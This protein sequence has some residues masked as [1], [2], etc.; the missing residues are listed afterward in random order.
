MPQSP[1]RRYALAIWLAGIALIGAIEFYRAAFPE[2]VFI[3][4]AGAWIWLAGSS[5]TGGIAIV[6]ALRERRATTRRNSS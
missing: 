3:A 6:L 1:I 2:G 5:V 4:T